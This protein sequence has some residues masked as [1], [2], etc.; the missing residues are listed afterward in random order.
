MGENSNISWCDHTF[1]PWIGCTAVSAACDL[2][3]ARTLM[4]DRYGRV[5][6]GPGQPRRRTKT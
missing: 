3:Y 1:N 2:C 6:W 5:T 4:Q